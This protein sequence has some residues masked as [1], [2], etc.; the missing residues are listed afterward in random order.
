MVKR[1]SIVPG[2]ALGIVEDL[3]KAGKGI[4]ARTIKV[5]SAPIVG[6]VLLTRLVLER[7]SNIA[8]HPFFLSHFIFS[9]FF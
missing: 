4:L 1:M 9:I 7:P 6:I 2:L 8:F 5:S 3:R